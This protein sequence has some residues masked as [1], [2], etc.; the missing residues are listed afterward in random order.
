MSE[1]SGSG[2]K[3]GFDMGAMSLADKLLLIG[4]VLLVI[5]S[6]MPWQGICI[7]PLG[8]YNIKATGGSGSFFGVLML[9]GALALIVWEIMGAMGNS[10]DVGG[11]PPAKVS[12]FLGL[13]V[14]VLGIVKFLL[15]A[16]NL[17]R[18]GSWLGLILI[19]VV[20]YGA[21]LKLKEAGV[22]PTTPPAAP[23]GGG[24]SPIA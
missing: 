6:F 1:P 12:G 14:A 2:G 18:W 13:G 5:D 17:G 24:D 8:C 23:S 15:A 10:I 16:F 3:G 19:L 11:M 4:G 22:M 7:G 9:L 20:A 21:F